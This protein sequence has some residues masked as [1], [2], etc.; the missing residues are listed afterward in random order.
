MPESVDVQKALQDF[1]PLVHEE[2]HKQELDINARCEEFKKDVAS[3]RDLKHQFHMYKSSGLPFYQAFSGVNGD[4]EVIFPHHQHLHLL[5]SWIKAR[6]M[7]MTVSKCL[8]HC[9]HHVIIQRIFG[10]CSYSDLE[11]LNQ[12]QLHLVLQTLHEQYYHEK[13]SI[14]T[15]C[16]KDGVISAN[17]KTTLIYHSDHSHY[18]ENTHRAVCAIYLYILGD[19]MKQFEIASRSEPDKCPWKQSGPEYKSSH[20]LKMLREG[21]GMDYKLSFHTKCKRTSGVGL[22]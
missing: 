13:R 5:K 1:I 12:A 7:N 4:T 17:F 10:L 18:S 8:T 11:L 21:T 3:L 2:I 22:Q 9:N 14:M 19:N 16:K 20:E 6:I 15:I